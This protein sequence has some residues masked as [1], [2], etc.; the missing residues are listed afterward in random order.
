[1]LGGVVDLQLVGQAFGLGG[2]EGVVERSRRVGIELIHDQHDAL[3]R[4]VVA[5][6]SALMQSAKSMRVRRSL[7]WTCRSRVRGR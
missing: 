3:C 2:R 7:T 5:S 4:G 6:T 1:M